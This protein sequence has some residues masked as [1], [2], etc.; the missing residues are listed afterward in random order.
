M[1]NQATPYDENERPIS[2]DFRDDMLLVRLQ[3]GRLIWTPLEWY[4]QLLE[5]TPDQRANVEFSTA[6]VHWEEL[7]VDLGV[8]G[9]LKR[10]RPPYKREPE[11]V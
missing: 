2:V 9:M 7:D 4:P 3:D 10:I 5:A 1:L 6:G 11:I 8:E